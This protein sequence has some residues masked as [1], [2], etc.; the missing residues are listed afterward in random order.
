MDMIK[1]TLKINSMSNYLKIKEHQ[2]NFVDNLPYE[3]GSIFDE[4]NIDLELKK[5]MMILEY[6]AV[7]GIQNLYYLKPYLNQSVIYG[8]LKTA[9][10]Q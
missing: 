1:S 10:W 4:N 5:N 8:L 7:I 6:I 2:I 3:L 9:Y